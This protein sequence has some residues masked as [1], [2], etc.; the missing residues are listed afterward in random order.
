MAPQQLLLGMHQQQMV[1]L[2]S[3]VTPSPELALTQAKPAQL[4][5]AQDLVRLLA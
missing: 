1:A 4:T 3:L 2:Q 5:A